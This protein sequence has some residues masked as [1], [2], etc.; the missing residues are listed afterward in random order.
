MHALTLASVL[1]G[2]CHSFDECKSFKFDFLSFSISQ[3]TSTS[4]R[5]HYHCY[6][7]RD[8]VSEEVK[9]RSNEWDLLPSLSLVSALTCQSHGQ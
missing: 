7:Y 1:S 8:R 4:L 5:L 9:I 6:S 2:L 3:V